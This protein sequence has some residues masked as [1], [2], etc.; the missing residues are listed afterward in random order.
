MARLPKFTL[1]HNEQKDRWDL[2]KDQSR[3]LIKSF[4]IKAGATKGGVLERAV[5]K[6]GGSVKIEKLNGRYQEERTYLFDIKQLVQADIFDSELEAARE[7]L[8]HKFV[9]AAGAIAG[10]VLEKHLNQV[11]DNHGIAPAKKNATISDYNDAMKTASV[12]DT[13]Q[14]RYIQHLGD[15]RNLCDHDKKNEPTV[16]QVG[17]LISGVDKLTKTLF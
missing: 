2:R 8:K 17:D 4:D 3:E 7:L 6:A 9:R 11:C 16:D 15:I 13:P 10:V 5:G 1:S 12:I 14:W